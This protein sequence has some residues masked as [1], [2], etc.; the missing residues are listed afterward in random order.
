MRQLTTPA[1]LI[2]AL[3]AGV[4]CSDSVEHLTS[5]AASSRSHAVAAPA[6]A[7]A[8]V[9]AGDGELVLRDLANPRGMT[10]GPGGALYVTEAGR[11]GAPANAGPC[12]QVV[13]PPAPPQTMCYGATGAI[14]RLRH[15]EQEQVVTG[16]PSYAQTNSGRAEGPNAISMNGLGNA[17]VTIGLEA[18][19][20]IRNQAPEFAG[21]GRL[22]HLSPWALSPGRG[23]G[24]G[25][26]AW[27]FVADLGQYELD[28][29]PDCGDLDSN[30]FGVL[31][32]GHDVIVADAGAN[33]YVRRSA[34]GA[35]STFAVF[36]NNTSPVGVPGCPEKSTNDFVP[37]SIIRG[38]HGAYYLGH[39]GGLPIQVG[40]ASVWRMERGGVPEPYLTGFTWILALAFDA[41]GNLYVLEHSSGSTTATPGSLIR[42]APDG[43]RSTVVTGIQRPGGLAVDDEGR[44][45]ISMIPGT[46][47][48][49]NGEVRRYT[50]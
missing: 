33:T 38:P 6:L 21:F 15:G 4:A 3:A 49:A 29:N 2:A 7:A 41:R 16:L 9:A 8:P 28:A 47:Y 22:V 25:K 19:P 37:T 45:Y 24:H 13:F 31:S 32:E 26:A 36:S 27:K 43:T 11:G 42:V 34:K 48:K 44:V 12:F 17:Y 35:L 46:N 30:P 18:S 20:L 5:P 23:K 10:F 1:A 40:G 39:L 50:P 14:T